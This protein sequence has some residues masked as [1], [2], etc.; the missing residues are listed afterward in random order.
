MIIMESHT[1]FLRNSL[2]LAVALTRYM[3]QRLAD[4][5]LHGFLAQPGNKAKPQ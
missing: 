5:A 1:G 3:T 4:N 2:R